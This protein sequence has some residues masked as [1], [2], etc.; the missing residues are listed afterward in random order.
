M[1]APNGNQIYLAGSGSD[2]LD[3]AYLT[4]V[5]GANG[6]GYGIDYTNRGG[7]DRV[8]G[9]WW[10][11]S[12][13]LSSGAE[14]IDGA[15]GSDTVNYSRSTAGVSV[16][17]NVVLQT[18]GFAQGDRLTNI[19]N[20][21][22]STYNDTLI[23]NAVANILLGGLGN[24]TLTGDGGDDI[25]D[26]GDGNDTLNGG[27]N[28]DIL[29][30]GLG[31]DTLI[32]GAG[33]NVLDGSKG[34]DTVDYSSHATGLVI[35]LGGGDGANGEVHE[36]SGNLNEIFLNGE[37]LVPKDTLSWI[38]N[39][40]GTNRADVIL[41]SE[42]ANTLLG[43]G[44]ADIIHGGDGGDNEQGGAGNDTLGSMFLNLGL[45][46]GYVDDTGNNRLF[47]G[48]GDDMLVGSSG[49]DRM[50]GGDDIDTVDYAGSPEAVTVNLLAGTGGGS[51][52]SW[53]NGDTFFSIQKVIG[54]YYNDTLVG[55][56]GDE[57]I[58]GGG[59]DDYIYGLSGND[60]LF[61]G[62]GWDT[63]HGGDDD[64][65]MTGGEG[66]DTFVF[67][68]Q[69]NPFFPVSE[70]GEGHDVIHD[71][72]LLSDRIAIVGSTL[73]DLTFTQDGAN[74]VIGYDDGNS[75]IT[76]ENVTVDDLMSNVSTAILFA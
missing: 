2:T 17:L 24:D 69:P 42:A 28:D 66:N 23:G 7:S 25:L 51:A 30:G 44:G 21:T 6:A 70:P 29:L 4:D 12:F 32:A 48:D 35:S 34:I 58:D 37:D 73:E 14:T 74:T 60:V 16:N 46:A 15:G 36:Y 41:G 76:L 9:T 67:V 27:T 53:S 75:T 71:F 55:S 13:T 61:G 3:F 65:K 72:E 43:N 40:N 62:T 47:G 18:G 56:T 26:G 10:D 64:D 63:I 5:L 31:N 49:A 57:T 20:V 19:E 39:V 11:D 8:K 1:R 59:L 52:T 33:N 38:E 50:D 22:G 45:I 68:T 54:S